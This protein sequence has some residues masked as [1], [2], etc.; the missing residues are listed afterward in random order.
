TLADK[1][2]DQGARE[3]LHE[4]VDFVVKQ[5][6][7]DGEPVQGYAR[8]DLAMD[9]QSE[10]K[11]VEAM[12]QFELLPKDFPAYTYAQGQA[13]FIALTAKK[14]DETPEG[15]KKWTEEAKKAMARMGALP[16]DA[17]PTTSLM[18]FF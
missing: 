6:Q 5:K 15:K 3:R 11:F 2:S 4:L 8:Y 13:V 1:E 9:L 7:W 10:E 18:W 16:A 12:K 14:A 17:N